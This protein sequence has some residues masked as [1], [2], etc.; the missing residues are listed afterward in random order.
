MDNDENLYASNDI[1]SIHAKSK[2]VKKIRLPRRCDV[3]EIY[4]G[5][6]VARDTNVI[7]VPME[8]FETQVFLLGE[9]DKIRQAIR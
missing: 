1:I 2:G 4:S 9:L 3:V 5:R 6:T 8:A 7:E